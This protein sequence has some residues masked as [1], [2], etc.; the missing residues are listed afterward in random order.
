MNLR[1]CPGLGFLRP[2]TTLAVCLLAAP[3][4]EA[5]NGNRGERHGLGVILYENPTVK[6]N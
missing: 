6:H 4:S 5:E 2:V 3:G 1:V